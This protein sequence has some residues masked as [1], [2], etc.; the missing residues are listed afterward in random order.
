MRTKGLISNP[1]IQ[2]TIKAVPAA[3]KCSASTRKPANSSSS[4]TQTPTVHQKKICALQLLTIFSLF[5]S[6]EGQVF[7]FFVRATDNGEP[8]KHSDVPVNILIMGPKDVPPIFERKDETFFLSENSPTGTVIT[9]LKMVSDIPVTYQV[10]SGREDNPQFMVDGQGQLT[11]ARPLNFEYQMS[12]VISVLALTDSSPPLTATVDVKL[13]VLDENDHE[14]HF[15]SNPYVLNLAE[16]VDKGTSIM[17]GT[18]YGF[19]VGVSGVY[20][21]CVLFFSDRAR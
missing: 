1:N 12:H 8:E 3:A 20:F 15:E 7:Q 10:I 11:L 16:N 18:F 19:D 14:P 21:F 4:K 9:K 13:Q 2:F 17:K 6:A 5:F